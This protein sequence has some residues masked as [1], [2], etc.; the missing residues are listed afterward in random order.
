MVSANL[1][2]DGQ[3]PVTRRSHPPG[4]P[5]RL[6]TCAE[7]RVGRVRCAAAAPSGWWELIMRFQ[8][9]GPLR[10]RDGAV[11]APVK[12]AQQRLVLAV[13]LAEA[14]RVV[15]TERLVHEIWGERPPRA[16]VSAVQNDVLRLRRILHQNGQGPLLTRGRGYELAIDDGDLDAR[17]FDEVV[18]RGRSA[19]AAGRVEVA[20]PELTEGLALWRG[21]ALADV[22]PSPTVDAYAARLEWSRVAA[23]EDRI[24]AHLQ[25]GQHADVVGEL[26]GLVAQHPLRERLWMHL[27]LALYRCGRRAEALESYRAAYRVLADE[28]GLAPGPQLQELQ[29]AIL[30]DDPQLRSCSAQ[31]TS[32]A[33]VVAVVPAQ[34]PAP[35]AGFAGRAGQLNLLDAAGSQPGDPP[36]LVITSVTGMAGVGKTTLALH[37]AHRVRDRFPDGQL[38]I[39]L[40]GYAPG[41]PVQAVEALSQFLTALGVPR[42]Q[43][44]SEVEPAAALYRTL[45]ADKRML[46]VLDNAAHPDQVRPLLPSTPTGLVVITSRDRLT[47]LIAHDGAITMALDVLSADETRTLLVRLLGREATEADPRATAELGV[48]CGH[49][50]LALR[51]AAAQIV[52]SRVDIATH[53]AHLRDNRLDVLDISGDPESAVRAAFSYSYACL[54]DAAQRLFRLLGL[55]PGEDVTVDTVAELAGLTPVETSR[56][57]RGLVEAHL[58]D[59]HASGR[60]ALH[61]LLRLYAADRAN[62][63]ECHAS[64]EAALAR[65]YDAYQRYA[66]AASDL[67][68]PHFLRLPAPA[69]ASRDPVFPGHAAALAWLDAERANLVAACRHTAERGPYETAWRL[70][71]CLR[72]YFNHCG[73]NVDWSTVAHAGL[74]AAEADAK[75]AAQA[76]A[77]LSLA[78]LHATQGR[79]A[80]AITHNTTAY[81]LARQ[82]GWSECES[83]ALGSLGVLYLSLGE[84]SPA[85]EHFTQ[86]LSISQRIGSVAAQAANRTN[87]GSVHFALGDLE[88]AADHH[89]Q[90]LD[91]Y[92]QINSRGAQASVM[93][94]LGEIDHLLG[95]VDR[96][97]ATLETT[98]AMLREIG[99]RFHEAEA[100]RMLAAVH[101]DRGD[102]VSALEHSRSAVE[103]AQE[104]GDLRQRAIALATDATVQHRLGEPARA[105][106]G[107][108]LAIEYAQTVNDRYILALA[109]VGLAT[110]LRATAGPD[111]ADQAA[112]AA[113]AVAHHH[114]YRLLEG[115]AHLALAAIRLDQDRARQAHAHAEQALTIHRRTGHRLGQ[116][117]A[118]DALAAIRHQLGHTETGGR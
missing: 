27:M 78:S 60:Y 109:Q 36:A 72:G 66:D 28:H 112:L 51:I 85:A 114:G 106:H 95:R 104:T 87:L 117:Q 44:P 84:L 64:R 102:H 55:V 65:L 17:R 75:P 113:L 38:F 71:D 107:Y 39:N 61:D 81:D 40:R 80:Q 1:G 47:G 54:P 21:E 42:E 116:T 118:H 77:C 2:R 110:A 115:N 99:N 73:S 4:F 5:I 89:R 14:C 103:L 34:L 18:A 10:V 96:A 20:L 94:N 68:T 26:H 9:L 67:L 62:A 83:N 52:T 24:G 41:A 100:L 69:R 57:L 76:S 3:L 25:L 33:P 63:D 7:W 90:A 12:A 23:V 37:W 82:A 91:L 58:V 105:V 8:V 32:V 86:S 29:Q 46:I 70:A 74:D 22:P 79:F 88:T 59:E 93:S 49:L 6:G 53:V 108:R 16:A 35:V 13:L 50:P 15:S 48:L 30:S 45:L 56:L 97:L 92:G 101:L 31:A 98:V 11:W 43:I 19:L 111:H